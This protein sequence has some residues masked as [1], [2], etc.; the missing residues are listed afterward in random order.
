[1]CMCVYA[2]MLQHVCMRIWVNACA[3]LYMCLF[4]RKSFAKVPLWVG[5]TGFDRTCF[6]PWMNIVRWIRRPAR[7]PTSRRTVGEADAEVHTTK[8]I[9]FWAAFIPNAVRFSDGRRGWWFLDLARTITSKLQAVTLKFTT[10]MTKRRIVAG[11]LR[12]QDSRSF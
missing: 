11:N 5:G 1:M 4:I 3:Y 10:K 8:G 12:I 7:T 2:Y 6:G 9:N